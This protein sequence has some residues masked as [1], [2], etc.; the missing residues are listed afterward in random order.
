ML[1]SLPVANAAVLKRIQAQPLD[2]WQH[3]G[4][5][6]A[7]LLSTIYPLADA[8]TLFK[9]IEYEAGQ[10]Q[11]LCLQFLAQGQILPARW[12][13][14]KLTT[15]L[16]AWHAFVQQYPLAVRLAWQ[17]GAGLRLLSQARWAL[18][19]PSAPEVLQ[20]FMQHVDDSLLA[21]TLPSPE[22]V[23]RLRLELAIL[24]RDSEHHGSAATRP[25]LG[26]P[27]AQT[28][29]AALVICLSEELARCLQGLGLHLG[30]RQRAGLRHWAVGLGQALGLEPTWLA[31]N[32]EEA[33]ALRQILVAAPVLKAAPLIRQWLHAVALADTLPAAERRTLA[34]AR[35]LLDPLVADTLDLPRD[36]I[37]SLWR[38]AGSWVIEKGQPLAGQVP[39]VL[40]LQKKVM[41]LWR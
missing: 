7:D 14:P 4:D 19:W 35:S 15:D 11:L 5:P 23:L 30:S 22:A 32:E 3:V 33:R 9:L 37:G 20:R 40:N 31:G 25:L 21:P 26:V 34:L 38:K 29:L 16:A 28:D 24:R 41:G 27:L 13:D 36:R 39:A 18:I 6:L 1:P 10:D 8:D 17:A 12:H 2:Y